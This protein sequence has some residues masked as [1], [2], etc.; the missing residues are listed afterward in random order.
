MTINNQSLQWK[1][2]DCEWLYS[3]LTCSRKSWLLIC[4]RCNKKLLIV[5]GCIL[6]LGTSRKCFS[7][8]FSLRFCKWGVVSLF[9]CVWCLPSYVQFCASSFRKL[10]IWL[11]LQEGRPFYAVLRLLAFFGQY[12]LWCCFEGTITHFLAKE[13]VGISISDFWQVS[14]MVLLNC[15]SC[16]CLLILFVSWSILEYCFNYLKKKR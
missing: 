11:Y 16:Y 13:S 12:C 7:I 5:N 6:C 15:S 2:M 9:P 1:F 8:A 14:C 3:M 10:A 4:S